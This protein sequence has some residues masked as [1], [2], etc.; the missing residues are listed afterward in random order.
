MHVENE[1]DEPIMVLVTI[2]G[3][4]TGHEYYRFSANVSAGSSSTPQQIKFEP[5]KA[6]RDAIVYKA[7][8]GSRISR[9][10][11]SMYSSVEGW[12]IRVYE[13]RIVAP[14]VVV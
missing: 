2:T 3:N 11:T 13:D 8:A 7:S 9:Y 5:Q 14:I 12:T 1:T 4:V 10:E 6:D